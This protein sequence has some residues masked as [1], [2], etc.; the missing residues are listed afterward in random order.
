M[1]LF[2]SASKT[3]CKFARQHCRKL[4][5][6]SKTNNTEET[7]ELMKKAEKY[8]KKQMDV[9]IKKHRK[10]MTKKIKNLSRLSLR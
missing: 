8:Y 9:S 10:E 2:S 3:P 4:K 5:R 1:Y 6:R 7:R